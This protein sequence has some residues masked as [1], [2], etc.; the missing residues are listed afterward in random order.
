MSGVSNDVSVFFKVAAILVLTTQVAISFGKYSRGV[1]KTWN[2]ME[3]NIKYSMEYRKHGMEY[4][5]WNMENMEWN[6]ENMEWNMENMEWNMENME[7]NMEN[8]EWNI[9]N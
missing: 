7:W 3:W 4:G 9:H 6:M 8:M 5:T 1:S 2:G